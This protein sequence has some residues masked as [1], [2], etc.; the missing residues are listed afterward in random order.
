[1]NT[2][3][4]TSAT[5]AIMETI[6]INGLVAPVRADSRD[7]P[8]ICGK[9]ATMPAKMIS[10]MPLPTPRLVICSPI[11]IKRIVPPVSVTTAVMRKNIPGSKTMP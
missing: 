10:E 7:C 6:S 9:R 4:A 1:M 2:M 5:A 8:Q 11:H 3:N